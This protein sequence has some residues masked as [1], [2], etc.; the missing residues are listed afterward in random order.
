[1]LYI[2]NS[3]SFLHHQLV[4]LDNQLRLSSR[5]HL[6]TADW[7]MATALTRF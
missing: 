3:L 2:V 5:V 1:M 4:Q 7:Q 6:R